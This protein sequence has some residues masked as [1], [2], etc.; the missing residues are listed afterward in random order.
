MRS[1]RAAG[2]AMMSCLM[3]EG[4][5]RCVK[6]DGRWVFGP[7]GRGERR[8]GREV[9]YSCWDGLRAIFRWTCGGKEEGRC[10]GGVCLGVLCGLGGRGKEDVMI[11][12]VSEVFLTR[13]D[14]VNIWF[15]RS[16]D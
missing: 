1:D 2:W 12:E 6:E 5:P 9:W 13:H 15:D 16:M 11:G 4:N 8:E 14:A 3:A 7:E 10:E